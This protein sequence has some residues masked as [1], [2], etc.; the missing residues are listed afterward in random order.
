M[1]SEGRGWGLFCAE[2]WPSRATPNA[3]SDI[4]WIPPR[5]SGSPFSSVVD[6]RPSSQEGSTTDRPTPTVKP[7]IA[8]KLGILNNSVSLGVP[9]CPSACSSVCL[10]VIPIDP[11]LCGSII[12]R[13]RHFRCD[14]AAPPQFPYVG[15][16]A[17]VIFLAVYKYP[18]YLMTAIFTVSPVS[19]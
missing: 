6:R 11:H 16:G 1:R 8:S 4:V 7:R 18:Y 2:Q 12:L 14:L 15:Y 17:G 5:R 10:S 19:V 3:I 9:V 13:V